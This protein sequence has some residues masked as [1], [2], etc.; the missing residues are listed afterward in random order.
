MYRRLPGNV[1]ILVS[2]FTV[3]IF[4]LLI[5]HLYP[6]SIPQYLNRPTIMPSI[7]HFKDQLLSTTTLSHTTTA[8]YSSPT[9]PPPKP[10]FP[11]HF[12]NFLTPEQEAI[13]RLR[14]AGIIIIFKTGA[15]EL[16]HLSIHLATTLRYHTASNILFFSDHQGTL[17]PF[18]L[19]DALRNVDQTLKQSD[20]DFEI[21][22]AIQRYQSTGRDIE[23]LREERSKGDGRSGWR[24]D[25]YKFLHIVEQAFEEQPDAKWYVFIETDSYVFW[26]NLASF[27]S[28]FESTRPMYI[29]SSV[30]SG[31]VAFAHGGSG[32]VLSNAAMNRLLG[33]EQPQG[34]AA[35]WDQR[36]KGYCCGDIGLGEALQEK[37]VLITVAHPLVNGYKP[38]TFTYGPDNHWCQPVVTMHHVL[39]HEVSSVW[40]YERRREMLM[41]KPNVRRSA[42]PFWY[43]D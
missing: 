31:S 39:P 11:Q 30:W 9:H 19:N 38:T 35:S 40:R 37:G 28:R 21:Y 12:S 33:P 41:G 4:Y 10:S 24:L 22:R 2:C 6:S 27:L 16:S 25:K 3:A 8:P 14:A 32:Y 36:M 26:D 29:G 7:I 5:T 20:P 43:N 1:L 15:Q 18:I 23:E 42:W 13:A 17:G 34:L